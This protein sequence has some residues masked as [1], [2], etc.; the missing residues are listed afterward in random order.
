MFTLIKDPYLCRDMVDRH[1]DIVLST[2]W[3]LTLPKQHYFD[4]A[5][6]LS[7]PIDDIDLS[8]GHVRIKVTRKVTRVFHYTRKQKKIV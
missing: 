5:L 7:Q 8:R 3:R 4:L 1:V 2:P 6:M